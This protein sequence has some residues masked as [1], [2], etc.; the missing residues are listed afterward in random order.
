MVCLAN[1]GYKYSLIFAHYLHLI[2]LVSKSFISE[3]LD[4]CPRSWLDG[5]FD[6]R[7]KQATV[8]AK[9]VERCSQFVIKSLF[10]ASLHPVLRLFVPSDFVLRILGLEKFVKSS[11]D[12]R[13]IACWIV[14]ELFDNRCRVSHKHRFS[15]GLSWFLHHETKIRRSKLKFLKFNKMRDLLK[16]MRLVLP[17]RSKMSKVGLRKVQVCVIYVKI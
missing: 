13:G 17:Q 10:E 6:C 7:F 14:C 3:A 11:K 9:V 4:L 8:L 16:I 1:Y 12:S 5:P 15:D 2:Q